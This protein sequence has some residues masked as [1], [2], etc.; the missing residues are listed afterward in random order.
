MCIFCLLVKCAGCKPAY[1][2][3]KLN[4]AMKVNASYL[5]HSPEQEAN[6]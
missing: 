6:E 2:A 1:F 3:E 5:F 4:L